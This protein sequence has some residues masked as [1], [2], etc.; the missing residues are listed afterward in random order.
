M[1][2]YIRPQTG[3]EILRW[4]ASFLKA[5]GWEDDSALLE[6]RLLLGKAWNKD[7]LPLVTTLD[8]LAEEQIWRAYQDLIN[9]RAGHEPLQYILG[10]SEFMSLTFRVNPAV[11]I[12]RSD[13]ELL[14]EEAIRVLEGLK[15]PRILDVGTGSGAIAV[16]LARYLP[17]SRIW[18]VDIS[19]QAL[20]VARENALTNRVEERISFLQGDLFEPLKA[21]IIFDLIV[22][23][24][25]YISE[26]E[27][28]SL[29][30]DVQKEP[31]RALLGGEDGLDYY[32][33]IA[34]R[35]LFFLR[36]QGELLLE[37][38][39]QQ[40][41]E[42]GRILR[43]QGYTGIKVLKDQAGRDRVVSAYKEK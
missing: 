13:T 23:N 26:E 27:Y 39:W 33:R 14:V 36:S 1:E 17:H 35:S 31:V 30:P 43:E 28:K 25:P 37:I 4:A 3:R 8:E 32:R 29:P 5:K 41:E 38:G 12:P 11:L 42:V 22:S 34:A 18:A 24:P 9:R 2:N 40:A 16:S 19:G 21:P 10:F 6:S 20:A 7:Q 15:A